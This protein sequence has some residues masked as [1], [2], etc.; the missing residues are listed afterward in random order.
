MTNHEVVLRVEIQQ[1]GF[2]V[3]IRITPLAK[4]GVNMG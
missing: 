2:F 3:S 1:N 4:G